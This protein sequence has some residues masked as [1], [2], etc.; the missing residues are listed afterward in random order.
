[1]IVME[2]GSRHWFDAAARSYE[3]NH[4]GCPW[5][6]GSH[7]VYRFQRGTKQIFSCQT[8]DFQVVHDEALGVFR[9]IE[10]EPVS[11][12]PVTMFEV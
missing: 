6:G 2:N 9:H 5:C 11:N 8:C 10:G 12:P 7:R 3:E 1:M 4:Q